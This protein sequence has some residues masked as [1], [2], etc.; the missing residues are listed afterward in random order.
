MEA[1]CLVAFWANDPIGPWLSNAG[2]G[3]AFV[4]FALG[5]FRFGLLAIVELMSISES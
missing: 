3:F 5:F 1:F 2:A 4:S